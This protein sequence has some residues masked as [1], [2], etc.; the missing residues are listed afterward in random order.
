MRILFI[1]TVI[2]SKNILDEIIK[3]KNKIVGVIGGKKTKFNSD[4][5]D[6]VKY[7]KFKKID[8]IYAENINSN[9]IL[10]WV[11]KKKPDIIFCIGWSRLLKKQILN[12]APKGVIGYHPSDLPKNRGRHP[13]IW[14]LALGLKNIGSCFFYMDEA[15]DT[16]RIISKKKIKIKKNFNSYLVYKKLIQVGKQQIRE[17]MLKIENN[18][19]KSSPQKKSQSNN[20]RKRSEI[21]GKIDWRMDAKNINNLV[22]ALTKPYPGAYFLFNE[23][24]I[25]VWR[26]KVINF[27]IKNFEPGKIIQHKNNLLIKCGNKALQLINFH[28][29]IN[30]NKIKYL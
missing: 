27:N 21:D 19:L 13:I 24:K 4:Y 23:K 17:I 16:G 28:P 30:L 25:V 10:K 2:F 5:C 3:S 8:S 15:A 9:K 20:W 7:S 14:S 26:S 11:K 29:K 6:L 12:I 1:G 18:K 22:N